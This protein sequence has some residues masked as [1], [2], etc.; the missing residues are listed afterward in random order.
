M[1]SLVI[2]VS[3]LTTSRYNCKTKSDTGS[4]IEATKESK[5]I[6]TRTTVI[7][8]GTINNYTIK[9]SCLDSPWDWVTKL[10]NEVSAFYT[11]DCKERRSC[12]SL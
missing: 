2:F 7:R 4:M 6:H 8:P 12:P 10:N 5:A 9:T 1:V 11:I 3:V